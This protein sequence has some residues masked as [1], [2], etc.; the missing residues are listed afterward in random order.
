MPVEQ[1]DSILSDCLLAAGQGIGTEK[2]VD[3]D[4]VA[5]WR[6]RYR[7]FFLHAITVRGNSWA[8]DRH[9]VTAVGRYLGQRA[10][11]H[12]AGSPSV[13]LRAAALASHDVETGCQMNAEREGVGVP[14][15]QVIA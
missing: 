2:S 14:T 3:F 15:P 4:V 5:W 12:A 8:A 10:L 1:I 11:Y 6:S 7:R 13:D 9:R